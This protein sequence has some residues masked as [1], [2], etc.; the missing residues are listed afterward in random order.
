MIQTIAMLV[1]IVVAAFA[2]TM[3]LPTNSAFA[4]TQTNS[5]GN[6]DFNIQ[7]FLSSFIIN[8]GFTISY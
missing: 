1:A 7:Q 5:Q 8:G 6:N 3:V 4:Q 2:A